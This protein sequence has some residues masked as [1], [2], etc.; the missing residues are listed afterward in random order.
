MKKCLYWFI[1]KS[2]FKYGVISM[3]TVLFALLVTFSG[4]SLA[5]H[6]HHHDGYWR[7]GVYINTYPERGYYNDYY[8]LNSGY[9]PGWYDSKGYY[10]DSHYGRR[11]GNYHHHHYNKSKRHHH[12]T[13]KHHHHNS[14]HHHHH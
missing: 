10:R 2:F 4:V 7:N 12:H 9:G 6:Y 8:Y 1:A 3:R 13:N 14:N 5:A 11:Y